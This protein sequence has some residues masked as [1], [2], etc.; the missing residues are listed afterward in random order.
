MA[1]NP[2]IPKPDP[3][4][5]IREIVYGIVPF[6]RFR[7]TTPQSLLM[8][9][10]CTIGFCIAIYFTSTGISFTHIAFIVAGCGFIFILVE[11]QQATEHRAKN[12]KIL[13][14]FER[15][16]RQLD[17]MDD[18]LA[19]ILNEANRDP[20]SLNECLARILIE[21]GCRMPYFQWKEYPGNTWPALARTCAM[22]GTGIPSTIATRTHR[23]ALESIELKEAM[24]EPETILSS[25]AIRQVWVIVIMVIFLVLGF[26]SMAMGYW[27]DMTI[28]F[29]VAGF[30]SFCIPSI[31]DLIPMFRPDGNAPIVG[32]GFIQDAK[33]KLWTVDNSFLVLTGKGNENGPVHL[34]FIGPEGRMDLAYTNVHD[35]EFIKLWQRWNHPDP[36][37]EL[38]PP[39]KT[40]Q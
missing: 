17:A 5:R 31:R 14:T 9:V 18:R 25:V 15:E 27:F 3:P 24:L 6:M 13:A 1:S 38:A 12:K 37:P 7:M 22:D 16:I 32:M 4:Q 20:D 34:H 29:S 26:R 8:S 11:Y 2:D 23:K 33:E 28:Y 36:R 35:P 10:I 39:T 21:A 30:F 40:D 19:K